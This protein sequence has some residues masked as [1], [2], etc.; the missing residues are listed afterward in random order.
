MMNA[1]I[2]RIVP[3]LGR[4][5]RLAPVGRHTASS[6]QQRRG[7]GSEYEQN[8]QQAISLNLVRGSEELFTVTF[9]SLVTQIDLKATVV[10]SESVKKENETDQVKPTDTSEKKIST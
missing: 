2:S 4:Y 1:A 8:V 7:Y 5:T 3:P 6:V 10:S 9:S